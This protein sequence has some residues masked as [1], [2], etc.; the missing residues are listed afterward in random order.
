MNAVCM[1][2][3]IY[4][5]LNECGRKKARKNYFEGVEENKAARCVYPL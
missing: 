4:Y 2:V 3:Y 1:Y 5:H